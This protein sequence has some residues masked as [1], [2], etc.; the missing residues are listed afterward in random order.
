MQF[1][2]YSSLWITS[3]LDELY[4]FPGKKKNML[5]YVEQ[6]QQVLLTTF[7]ISYRIHFEKNQWAVQNND[8]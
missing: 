5:S 6:V 1:D 2:G 7:L 3:L 4:P 8:I